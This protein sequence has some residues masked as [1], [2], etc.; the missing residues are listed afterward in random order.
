MEVLNK[1]TESSVV[2]FGKHV[3]CNRILNAYQ[4]TL[5]PIFYIFASIMCIF[6][7]KLVCSS[8]VHRYLLSYVAPSVLLAHLKPNSAVLLT[9][10]IDI[11]AL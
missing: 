2:D 3:L 5:H 10:I 1:G 8:F 9:W 7:L 11:G 6:L 4:A